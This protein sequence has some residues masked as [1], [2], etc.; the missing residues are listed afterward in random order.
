MKHAKTGPFW[1]GRVLRTSRSHRAN[2]KKSAREKN[3]HCRFCFKLRKPKNFGKK[4]VLL[5]F[6]FGTTSIAPAYKNHNIWWFRLTGILYL[7]RF[8][9]AGVEKSSGIACYQQVVNKGKW[10]W[11]NQ[12]QKKRHYST[13]SENA[14]A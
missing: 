6:F 3:L 9:F 4:V 12:L 7:V 14:P 11:Q 1:V 5:L 2:W 13:D 10:L 8:S